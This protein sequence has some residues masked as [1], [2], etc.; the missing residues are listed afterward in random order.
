M[1]GI[2][3]IS[4]STISEALEKTSRQYLVGNLKQQQLIEHIHDR[5]VEV[6]VSYYKIFTADTPHIHAT[7]SEY[8]YVLQGSTQ[9]KNLL[10]NEITKLE[11]GDFYIVNSNTA[12][13]QKSMPD[14]KILFF[15]Y[16]GMNDKV[17]VDIDKETEI[18]LDK[19][20]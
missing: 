5:D 10:T 17:P 3:K 14:T 6:G 18:W 12:Y 2:Q 4:S 9:I 19:I 7:V 15:K 20:E 16:P 8:Q 11:A 13:A 1:P